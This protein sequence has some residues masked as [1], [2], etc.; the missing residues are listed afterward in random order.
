M[1]RSPWGLP[2]PP[3]MLNPSPS[4]P[5]PRVMVLYWGGLKHT[6]RERVGAAVVAVGCYLSSSWKMQPVASAPAAWS[7]GGPVTVASPP[8]TTYS[9]R[10]RVT[11]CLKCDAT[12][13]EADRFCRISPCRVSNQI[14]VYACV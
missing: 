7:C 10:K 6:V 14:L 11:P 13:G 8:A 12:A 1:G 4:G 9:N 2:Y 3:T 5:L